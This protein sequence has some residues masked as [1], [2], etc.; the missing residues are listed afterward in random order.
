VSKEISV[1]TV[2]GSHGWMMM[3]VVQ[4]VKTKKR[5]KGNK[6][7]R[8]ELKIC[9]P[10]DFFFIA[11]TYIFYR[12]STITTM[13]VVPFLIVPFLILLTGTIMFL[14]LTFYIL[15]DMYNEKM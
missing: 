2:A 7:F 1:K 3:I 6:M 9:I 10:L 8:D 13:A 4:L 14:A 11:T 12:A 15:W 5:V